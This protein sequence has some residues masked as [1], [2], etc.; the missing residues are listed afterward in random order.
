[1]TPVDLILLAAGAS[2]RMGGRDKLI[3]PVDGQ[4]LLAR[5]ADE[6]LASGAREVLVVLPPE[7]T[8][9]AAALAGRPVRVVLAPDHAEGMGASLRAGATALR[10]DTGAAIVLLG[11]MPDVT[12]AAI[13]ALIAAHGAGGLL[14]RAASGDI[15]GHPVLFDRRYFP[16][17]RGLEGDQGARALLRA[18]AERVVTVPT[19]GAAVDLDTPEAWAAWR[20]AHPGR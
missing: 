17:L 10:P 1:M 4:P 13:D 18:E 15:P 7:A 19:E 9:R 20:A 14:C 6:A 11:D 8:A 16:A 3:E 2:R 12:S 5:L